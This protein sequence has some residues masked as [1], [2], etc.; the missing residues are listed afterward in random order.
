MI[1]EAKI[2]D[3]FGELTIIG[4]PIYKNNRAKHWVCFCSCGAAKEVSD[5]RLRKGVTKTCG[6]HKVVTEETRA[7]LSTQR[8]KQSAP[9]AGRTFSEAAKA[10]MSAGQT[11]RR[12][13]EAAEKAK[14]DT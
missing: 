2:G 3:T 14:G 12:A 13:K 1:L 8:R 7:L 9:N 5:Y 6:K 4:G 10:R 11:K